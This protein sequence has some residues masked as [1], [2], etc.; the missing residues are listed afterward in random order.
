MPKNSTCNAKP[1]AIERRIKAVYD[2]MPGSER[3]LADRVLEYPGEVIV[4]S[5]TELAA[6][7][8]AS[9][10]AV[11]RFVKRLG[12]ADFREMQKEIRNAQ[13][14]GDP[15]FLSAGTQRTAGKA[16]ALAAHVENDVDCLRQTLELVDEATALEV[17]EAI[18]AARRIVCVGFRNSQFF[19]AYARRLFVHVRGNVSVLPGPG[20]TLMEDMADLGREDLIFAIGM[21]RRPPTLG[22]LMALMHGRGVP[23]A[24]ITDRRAV[25]T[26]RSA[27]WVLPCHVRGTSLFDSYV[28]AISLINFLGTRATQA[29]GRDGRRR[30]GKI[31]EMLDVLEELDADN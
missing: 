12:Y 5:A 28:G 1:R 10:A 29:A 26:S 24:Y 3:A 2:E 23:I 14:T 27:R 6:L 20:Q 7:S 21:R 19:A 9:K 18:V 4:C 17:A 30:L 11:S 15:I 31:E 16:N 13:T 8:G 22:R 25:T